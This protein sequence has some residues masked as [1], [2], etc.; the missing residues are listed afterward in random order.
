MILSRE[1]IDFNLSI[2][3]VSDSFFCELL[4]LSQDVTLSQAISISFHG[5]DSFF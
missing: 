2:F 4:F 3:S 1:I 5:S